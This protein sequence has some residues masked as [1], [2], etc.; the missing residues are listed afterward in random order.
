MGWSSTPQLR[1]DEDRVDERLGAQL[2][3]VRVRASARLHFGFLDLNGSL[4]RRFGSLGVAL[5]EPSLDLVLTRATTLSASGPGAERVLSTARAAAS[6]LGTDDRVAVRVQRA[7][8]SHAG[9]GSGTQLSLAVAAAM[10]RLFERP[11]CSD[12]AAAALD[13]GHRSGV[14]LAAFLAGGFILDGGRDA[15]GRSPPILARYDFPSSWRILLVIDENVR[16][17]HGGAET[18]A[19]KALPPFPEASAAKLCRICLMQVLPAARLGEFAAFSR[20]IGDIQ[21]EVG[22]FFAPFQGGGR[23][24]SPAVGAVLDRLER[25]GIGGV[26]QSSWGPTGFALFPTLREAERA[27]DDLQE[28][29]PGLRFMIVGGRNTGAELTID[30]PDPLQ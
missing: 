24:T 13:R 7:I 29:H 9:F 14:G 4:G 5:E 28:F 17:I 10:A 25:A 2:E 19:F 30:P 12:E 15:S 11:F 22:E 23:Y 20:G 21:R 1:C 27:L 8:P 16:G 26:G 6:F 18:S 3:A